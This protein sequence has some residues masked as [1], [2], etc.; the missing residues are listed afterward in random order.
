MA[1]RLVQD[2]RAPEIRLWIDQL[3]IPAGARWDVAVEQALA[4]CSGIVILLSQTSVMSDNVL[5]EVSFAL[6]TRKAVIPVVVD[7]CR[8]PLRLR[9]FE[10]ID[11]RRGYDQALAAIRDAIVRG[12]MGRT[13]SF[14]TPEV[15]G[16]PSI[17]VVPFRNVTDDARVESLRDGLLAE[18]SEALSLS[19][20][21][22]VISSNTTRTYK[23]NVHDVRF[24]ASDLGVRYV[25][26]GS[27]MRDGN[28]VRVLAELSN[29]ETCRLLWSEHFDH[30]LSDVFAIQDEIT[31]AIAVRLQ[32]RVVREEIK[33]AARRSANQQSAWELFH[34]ARTYLLGHVKVKESIEF[35]RR[36]IELDPLLV[37]AR[38]LLGARLSY[39]I[40]YGEVDKLVESKREVDHALS[41]APTNPS[42]LVASCI[43][44]VHMGQ[45]R[46]AVELA[47]LAL[48]RNPNLAEAWAYRGLTLGL[49]GQAQ[50]GIE[51]LA[52][53][54]DLSPKDP[55]RY[56]W[57][58]FRAVCYTTMEDHESASEA[59]RA[60]VNLFSGWFFSH[61]AHAAS[62]AMTRRPQEAL[63]AWR[64]A[65]HLNGIV[66]LG[67]YR[68]WLDMSTLDDNHRK[69]IIE[70]L[71]LAGCS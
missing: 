33:R 13:Q 56:M 11:T 50:D 69:R 54:F 41:L 63:A 53:A 14:D 12:G 51:K 22:F 64:E 17:A 43:A 6:E 36:A 1:L 29:G 44:Y 55:L 7:G 16:R 65:K 27:L 59:A 26:T 3:D 40:W 18:V 8:V 60:S 23:D 39:L 25:V 21:F 35:L 46:R 34:R 66:S 38:A 5:D 68:S 31:K 48:E 42:V 47:E 37:E 32:P 15:G 45:H 58:L 67:A 49:S 71:E 61:M 19:S 62:L 2:L 52:Y 57:H 9:R 28:R 24:I 30:D 20:D 10:W 70:Q 4:R